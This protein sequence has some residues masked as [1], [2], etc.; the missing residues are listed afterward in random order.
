MQLTQPACFLLHA[1]AQRWAYAALQVL[2]TACPC[3][4]VLSTPA[5]V[6]CALARAAQRGVLIKSGA[7]LEALR[8][9][10]VLTL[11]KTGTLTKGAFQVVGCEAAP[12][13]SRAALLRAL[14]SL[15]RGSSHGLAAAVLG[16]AAA[17]VRLGS[18]AGPGK[19]L[20]ACMPCKGAGQFC[21]ACVSRLV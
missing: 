5:A 13:W 14:G 19:R 18:G 8:R 4:L 9:V 1:T 2:V 7:A 21:R 10:S 6:V 12:G 11:D 17:Q 20:L 15:E 3:A 16:Y